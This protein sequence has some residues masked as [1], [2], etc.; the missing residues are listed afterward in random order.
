MFGFFVYSRRSFA[1]LNCRLNH[2]PDD[3]IHFIF[4]F[5]AKFFCRLGSIALPDH[6]L[7]RPEQRLINHR[8]IRDQ[9]QKSTHGGQDVHGVSK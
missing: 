3:L 8:P 9:K 6:D 7:C 2:H 5:P 1:R 4:R